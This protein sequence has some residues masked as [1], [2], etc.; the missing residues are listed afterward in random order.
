M[1]ADADHTGLREPLILLACSPSLLTNLPPV[2]LRVKN[3]SVSSL[4]HRA[5]R[6]A[7]LQCE[8]SP[9]WALI[10]PRIYSDGLE[11]EPGGAVLQDKLQHLMIPPI[12]WRD[13]RLPDAVLAL[14]SSEIQQTLGEPF[15]NIT[16]DVTSTDVRLSFYPGGMLSLLDL[17]TLWT[18][19]A[20]LR[21]RIE[22]DRVVITPRRNH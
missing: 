21:V 7:G 20:P 2:T 14:K 1:N 5:A 19:I 3:E 17:L 9:R 11:I 4:L 16:L 13:A 6:Q 18:K 22:K 12:E 10:A 8:V 15:T